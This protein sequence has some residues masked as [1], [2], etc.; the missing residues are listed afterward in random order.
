MTVLTATAICKR[1][2]GRVVL[3]DVTVSFDPGVSVLL[4]R[5]GAGKTTLTD[6]VG[7]WREADSGTIEV[8]GALRGSGPSDARVVGVAPQDLAIYPTLTVNE[9]LRIFADLAGLT[10]R[11]R[12]T[13]IRAV[14]EK[15]GIGA[16]LDRPA[17]RLSGGQQRCLHTAIALI[18][19]PPVVLLDEPTVG[20][21]I[22]H[23]RALIEAVRAIGAEGRTV[24]YTTHYLAEVDALQ[25]DA[26]V[27]LDAGSVRYRGSI[28]GLLAG[29]GD[30]KLVIE[31]ARPVIPP[32]RLSAAVRVD[33]ARWELSVD[34]AESAVGQVLAA[35][36]E[37]IV[38]LRRIEA[39]KVGLE[40]AYLQL[41]GTAA[42]KH[43]TNAT[44]EGTSV[45]AS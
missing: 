43:T 36:G 30:E 31:F 39:R 15:L 29:S 8:D 10:S 41:V 25:P 14:T 18:P 2:A 13:Q 28:A 23:R 7:G 4:G 24:V 20:V 34:A 16:L 6:I 9:N 22:E 27:V 44:P 5:N 12:R 19:E 33:G 1:Y 45:H 35:L 38:L 17:G 11:D 37:D 32:R 26:V 21:D 3:D 42:E 40:A